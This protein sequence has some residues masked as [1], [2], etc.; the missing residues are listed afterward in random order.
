MNEPIESRPCI[1][2]GK[3]HVVLL[4]VP[5]AP[6]GTLPAC[7]QHKQDMKAVFEAYKAAHAPRIHNFQ[8]RN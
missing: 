3:P 2:C 1:V 8:R 5:C 4:N 6:G 7:E